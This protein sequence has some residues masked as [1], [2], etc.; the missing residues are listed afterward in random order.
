VVAA[1][2]DEAVHAGTLIKVEY[3]AEA[4]VVFSPD[5]AKDAV[6]PRQFLWPVASSVGDADK[7]IAQGAL[8]IDE[9]YT[10]ADRHHNQM[11]PH[12]T[13]AVLDEDGSLTLYDTTQHIF[14]A[15]ELVSIVLGTPVE[16]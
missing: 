11:E 9:T 3:A 6:E 2:R 12:A 8:R 1:T 7:S 10:T 16:K 4:P 14:G 5:S 13:T 15:R